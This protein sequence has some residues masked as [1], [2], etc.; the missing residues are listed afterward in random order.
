M[1]WAKRVEVQRAQKVILDAAKENKELYT[2]L[3]NYQ[4]GND[5]TLQKKLKM[6]QNKCRY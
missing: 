5:Q 2:I 4:E 6:P 3:R 1:Y